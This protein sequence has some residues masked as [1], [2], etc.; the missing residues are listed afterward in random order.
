MGANGINPPCKQMV[1]SLAGRKAALARYILYLSL[2]L[3]GALIVIFF[4]LAQVAYRRDL[5][6]N[7]TTRPYWD[8]ALI[9]LLACSFVIWLFIQRI[10]HQLWYQDSKERHAKNWFELAGMGFLWAAWT[11][12]ILAS[13]ILLP[14]FVWAAQR[15]SLN[16]LYCVLVIGW[17][18]WA[19]LSI[20][21]FPSLYIV[22]LYGSW[23]THFYDTWGHRPFHKYTLGNQEN[24]SR[25]R[26][27]IER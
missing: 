22:A 5:P 9:A 6:G 24:G 20:L 19:T 11:G 7:N 27:R 12:S 14:S 1:T 8:P 2:F 4:F 3:W 17:I 21:L 23:N 16:L 18:Q 26:E 13:T 15:A 10:L 25:N